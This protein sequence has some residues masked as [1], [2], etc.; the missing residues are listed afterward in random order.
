MGRAVVREEIQICFKEVH[1]KIFQRESPKLQG[2]KQMYIPLGLNH[3][4]LEIR[5]CM[6]RSCF[7]LMLVCHII[8]VKNKKKKRKEGL[9]FVS[10]KFGTWAWVAN[11]DIP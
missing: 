1:L 5:I 11:W 9:G 6:S 3:R 7:P 8:K 4:Q 2:L 10:Q